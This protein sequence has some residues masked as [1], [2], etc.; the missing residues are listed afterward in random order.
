MMSHQLW[1]RGH[2]C[3]RCYVVVLGKQEPNSFEQTHI[4][5]LGIK[6]LLQGYKLGS[7][8]DHHFI[9][10]VLRIK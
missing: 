2:S 1:G 9:G 4:I 3:I 5:T 10:T 8:K 6:C 7:K